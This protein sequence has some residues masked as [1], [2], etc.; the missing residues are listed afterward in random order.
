MGVFE[1]AHSSV[2]ALLKTE[3]RV[4]QMELSHFFQTAQIKEAH[5][6]ESELE[7]V[8]TSMMGAVWPEINKHSSSNTPNEPASPKS[9]TPLLAKP[10]A[11]LPIKALTT[12]Q[13]QAVERRRVE[14]EKK[15][16]A[17]AAA[18]LTEPRIRKQTSALAP[19]SAPTIK[20]KAAGVGAIKAKAAGVGATIRR[21][22]AKP[23]YESSKFF[24]LNNAIL[25]INR[26]R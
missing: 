14:V 11:A 8:L 16:A 1:H 25:T 3:D 26:R 2:F 7:S 13:R 24:I 6:S 10:I 18:I 22:K 5:A 15:V 20:A 21:G 23:K 12:K 17:E 19:V 4:M 9:V